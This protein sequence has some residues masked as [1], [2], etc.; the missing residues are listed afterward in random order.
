MIPIY[1][2]PLAWV[3]IPIPSAMSFNHSPSYISPSTCYNLPLPSALLLLNSPRVKYIYKIMS[4]Y[5]NWKYNYIYISIKNIQRGD[6]PQRGVEFFSM[7]FM[8]KFEKKFFS[9]KLEKKIC[10]E[11]KNDLKKETLKG[12]P[13]Q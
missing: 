8:K 7:V 4:K 3:Y 12:K 10:T 5:T 9:F 6:D 1:V 13:L 2:A 11:W